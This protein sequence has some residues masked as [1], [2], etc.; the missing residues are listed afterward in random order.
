MEDCHMGLI[1]ADWF[2]RYS[3]L[4]E[5]LFQASAAYV[6]FLRDLKVPDFMVMHV[7]LAWQPNTDLETNLGRTERIAS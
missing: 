7:R 1:Y 5:S 6:N 3:K 4:P 2:G